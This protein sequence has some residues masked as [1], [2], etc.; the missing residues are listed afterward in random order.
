MSW[1]AA[2]GQ[3]QLSP[4]AAAYLMC[5]VRIPAVTEAL[6]ER[7][8]EVLHLLF[9]ITEPGGLPKRFVS[10]VSVVSLRALVHKKG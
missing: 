7:E 8:K 1:P 4:Q 2:A 9:L 10:F 5:E 6:T 3:V